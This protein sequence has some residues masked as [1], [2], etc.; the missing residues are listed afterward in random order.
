MVIDEAHCISDWG[1][2]FRPDYQRLSRVLTGAPGVPVL[3]TTATANE[4]VTADVA[5]QLGDATVVLRGGL[6]RSSLRLSVVDGLGALERYAWV[7]QALATLPGSGIVY[8]PTVAET[9]A[10]R[11]LPR[12]AGPCG[13]RLLGPARS[14][15]P[16]AG[17]GRA[18]RQRAEGGG[19]DLRAGDGLRQARPRLLRARGIARLAGRLLPADRSRGP[20]HRGG[21]GRAV[22]GRV[23]RTDLGVLRHRVHAR[24]GAGPACAR[25]PRRGG[26]A[27]HRPRPR[28][29]HRHPAWAPG[30]APARGGGRR[31]RR[32][33]VVGMGRHRC[34]VRVRRGEVGRDPRGTGGRGRFDARLRARPRVPD[35]VP[36]ARPRR[37]RPRAVREVLRVHG[38]AARAG[39][40]PRSRRG[41]RRTGAPPR[42]RHRDRAAQALAGRCGRRPEGHHRRRVRRP[43]AHLC[44]HAGLG[45][46]GR[47]ARRPRPA[48]ARRR[49]RR[50][51][52][53][54][55]AVAHLVARP[56]GGGGADAVAPS[57]RPRARPRRA[58]RGRGQA[59]ARRSSR[60]GR[61][62]G[63]PTT[64]PRGRG[65]R[66]C[67]PG[68]RSAPMW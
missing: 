62:R 63:R 49:H 56:S 24:P 37:S 1:F 54:A 64:S 40:R 61:A 68:C 34:A 67:S 11:R 19:R 13:R 4:R 42:C 66:R 18:A 55:R 17:R 48:P 26:G 50:D 27:G 38:G 35:G 14:R 52:R 3:A 36:P 31:R 10:A 59:P 28:V 12:G 2:D 43:G 23:R 65:S 5:G 8:V 57:F 20:G 29:G 51:G 58:D 15:G 9:D 46:G 53:G 22:A 33:H 16:H 30:R 25:R 47:R 45:R 41:R 32:A 60:R 39:T 21:G 7:D 6:A 44:R